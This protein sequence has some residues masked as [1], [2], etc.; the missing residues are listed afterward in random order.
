MLLSIS[1]IA[2]L[3]STHDPLHV[4]WLYDERRSHLKQALCYGRVLPVSFTAPLRLIKSPTK[5]ANETFRFARSNHDDI[6]PTGS[7]SNRLSMWRGT[8]SRNYVMGRRYLWQCTVAL[9]KPSESGERYR[10]ND[11]PW[12]YLLYQT[13]SCI[14]IVL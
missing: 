12:P 8:S 5:R 7:Q 14:L 2:A 3:N 6:H 10:I 1:Q 9:K 11:S 4:L 13:T